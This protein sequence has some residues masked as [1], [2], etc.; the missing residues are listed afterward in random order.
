MFVGW[1]MMKMMYETWSNLH[2]NTSPWTNPSVWLLLGA[3]KSR[4]CFPHLDTEGGV[5]CQAYDFLVKH[6]FSPSSLTHEEWSHWF[7][8]HIYQTGSFGVS[9]CNLTQNTC[10]CTTNSSSWCKGHYIYK[11]EKPGNFL[12]FI[13]IGHPWN[14]CLHFN[15][16]DRSVF[17]KY[18]RLINQSLSYTVTGNFHV[19]D[20]WNGFLLFPVLI[21]IDV[22]CW[23]PGNVPRWR[24]H[25][26]R[27]RGRNSAILERLQQDSI[28]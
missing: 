22:F 7:I 19:L 16:L 10:W 27:G 25:S 12:C 11:S 28:N 20:K 8:Q 24:G 21:M 23:I 15:V 3:K 1:L 6:F 17:G 13:N 14:L 2:L 9:W 4:Y 26:Y 5:I 18:N